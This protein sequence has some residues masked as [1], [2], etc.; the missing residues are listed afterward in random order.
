MRKTGVLLS[1]SKA[2]FSKH[3]HINVWSAFLRVAGGC[4]WGWS[5]HTAAGTADRR[6]PPA[7]QRTPVHSSPLTE[8]EPKE[9]DQRQMRKWQIKQLIL[10]VRR[11][12]IS[13][14]MSTAAH[15][16]TM[17]GH[18][19]LFTLL[20]GRLVL[21]TDLNFAAV[22]PVI[23]DDLIATRNRVNVKP[24]GMEI[25]YIHQFI[26]TLISKIC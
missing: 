15:P 4:L 20:Y 14:Q 2:V 11:V 24:L 8:E 10:R 7:H 17:S 22:R 1:P 21:Q 3:K 19:G 12:N 16:L 6:T 5:A 23:H 25:F 26:S 9:R 13:K 18:V